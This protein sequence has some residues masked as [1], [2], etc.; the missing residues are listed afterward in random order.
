MKRFWLFRTNLTNL[1]SYHEYSD[2]NDFERNLWDFYLL[3]GLWLLRNTECKEVTIWRLTKKSSYSIKFKFDDKIFI[4]RFVK[5]FDECFK[6]NKPD[7]TFFRGGFP[8]YCLITK[9]NPNFFGTKLYLG[10]SKRKYPIYGGVYD[11]ILIESD[12]DLKNKCIPFYKI[13]PPLIFHPLNLEKKWDMCWPCN[14]TQIK[15]KGQEYF[16][17]QISKSVVLRNLKIVHIG[18]DPEIGKLICAKYGIKNIEF[19]G[20][21]N[22]FDANKV[23]NQSKFGIVTSNDVDGCP[24]ISTEILSSGTPLLIRKETRLLDYYRKF[25]CVKTF[26]D[27]ELKKIYEEAKKNYNEMKQKNLELLN[28]ELSLD[29]IMRMNLKLW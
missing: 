23:I 3:Q 15:F 5:N 24:R 6:Y 26:N 25:D 28:N 9:K 21:V 29:N 1:E 8:E 4:Q 11:K 7:I 27:N 18:N 16:I 19:L 10:A 20:H 22:R 12:Q 2:P 17:Q 14:F 13:G